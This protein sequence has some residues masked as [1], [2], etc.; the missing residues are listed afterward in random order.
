VK[1][2]EMFDQGL[3][4]DSRRFKIRGK[5]GG[6]WILGHDVESGQRRGRTSSLGSSGHNGNEVNLFQAGGTGHLKGRET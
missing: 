1:A 6:F 2:A 5:D 4:P 3:D